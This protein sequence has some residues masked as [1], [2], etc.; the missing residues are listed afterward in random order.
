MRPRRPPLPPVVQPLVSASE[1]TYTLPEAARRLGIPVR[2][3]R[4]WLDRGVVRGTLPAP[5]RGV[6]RRLTASDLV[7][8]RALADLQQLFGA[9]TLRFS[10]KRDS[11]GRLLA[12]WRWAAQTLPTLHGDIVVIFSRL[13]RHTTVIDPL[14]IDDAAA[15]LAQLPVAVVLNLPA[16][17]RL[18]NR[19]G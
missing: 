19:G 18:L 2:R 7:R 3:L 6:D 4:G 9:N 10:T 14:P 16:L 15:R 1:P 12:D 13:D 5:R 11:V 17:V 8:V